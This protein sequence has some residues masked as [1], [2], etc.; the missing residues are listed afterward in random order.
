MEKEVRNAIV[1]DKEEVACDLVLQN[2]I[3]WNT[4]DKMRSEGMTTPKRPAATP[5]PSRKRKYHN[6]SETLQIDKDKLLHEAESWPEDKDVNWSQ[7]AREY[8]LNSPNGGQIIK[9]FLEQSNIPYINQRPSRAKRR[10]I[11]KV[12]GEGVTFPMYPPVKHERQKLLE[13]I[14]KGEIAIGKEVVPSSYQSYTVDSHTHNIQENTHNIQENTVHISARKI[15]LIDIRKKLLE[16]HVS[17]GIVRDSSDEYF[18]NLSPEDIAN[19][20]QKLGMSHFTGD[21]IQQLK[22]MCRTRHIKMWHDHSS[23]AAHGYLL[24]LVS[25]IYDPA[26]FYTTEK[27]KNLKGV[28]VDVP[29]ILDEAEVHIL[30]RSSSSTKYQLMFIET[31]RECL[32]ETKEKVCTSN[33]VEVVDV[34]RF[35]YG[36]GPAAQFE[37]GHKQGGTYCCVGCGAESER[38]SDIAYSYRSQKLSLK[39]RQQFV[40]QGKAWK[41]GG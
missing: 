24:V 29:A 31:R 22:D 5:V 4:Y 10:C 27:M 26:F 16:K 7:L 13:R 25:V 3:S 39:E 19:L 12:G 18:E 1:K 40:V 23:I 35:F 41:K 28:D 9:E 37:A 34:V 30:G 15:S 6:L 38:F 14:E 36:D 20:S 11:K 17:L 33:G 2:R 21:K 8:G 32:K